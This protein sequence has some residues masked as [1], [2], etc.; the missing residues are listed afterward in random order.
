MSAVRDVLFNISAVTLQIRSPSVP[1][2]TRGR[3]MACRQSTTLMRIP[4]ALMFT[5]FSYV[6]VIV[7]I[8]LPLKGSLIFV[9][10]RTKLYTF[11][12]GA[13]YIAL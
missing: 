12:G 13:R 4:L 2:E 8:N 5:Y 11:L 1:S 3:T 9:K 7:D 10:D 6:S